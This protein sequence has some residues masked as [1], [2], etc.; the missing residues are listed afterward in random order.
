MMKRIS[1]KGLGTPSPRRERRSADDKAA[2]F[3]TFSDS[4]ASVSVAVKTTDCHS[5]NAKSGD[6]KN[7]DEEFQAHDVGLQS[8]PTSPA[9]NSTPSRKPKKGLFNTLRRKFSSFPRKK[10]NDNAEDCGDLPPSPLLLRCEG[11]SNVCRQRSSPRNRRET[12]S[13]VRSC[14]TGYD[15]GLRGASYQIVQS[16]QDSIDGDAT[17]QCTS[18][19][20]NRSTGS[21]LHSTKQSEISNNTSLEDAQTSNNGLIFDTAYGHASAPVNGQNDDVPC[22]CEGTPVR[23]PHTLPNGS[24]KQNQLDVN[25]Q[26]TVTDR[27]RVSYETGTDEVL[28]KQSDVSRLAFPPFYDQV[29]ET[30]KEWSLAAELFRLSKYGWY[31]GPI[32]RVEAEEKLANQLDGAFLVRD[33]SDERY[34]LSLSF[35]SFGRTLHTRVEHCNGVFSFYAQPESEG[36]TSIV[37]LIEHSMTDSKTGV[38]CY[39]R[40]RAP[41]APSFPVRL[42]KPVS[43]FTHVRS[44][45]YLCRFVIRQYTRFDHIQTLPLPTSIKG[46]L[47]ENQY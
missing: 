39:S 35:R 17:Q 24:H 11:A 19:H 28:D 41:G 34:L 47:E 6:D 42:T 45:Q 16:D 4:S 7:I 2:D 15:R 32:T 44:L 33:S 31:W 9:D 25:L 46:W 18:A 30:T 3:D 26:Q 37:D 43:R 8:L 14:S 1:G 13:H 21:C 10:D 20:S 40:A 27:P 38:F 29:R 36:Y 12:R 23:P 5:L 22:N